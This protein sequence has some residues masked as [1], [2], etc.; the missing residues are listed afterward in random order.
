MVTID[1]VRLFDIQEVGEVLKTTWLD[2]YSAYLSAETI[3]KVT[4]F[5]LDPELLKTQIMDPEVLFLAAKDETSAIV[6]LATA[7]RIEP[8][9][10]QLARLYVLP[11]KQ[12]QGIGTL[13]LERVIKKM[14]YIKTIR[15]EVE[16]NNL[17]GISFCLKQGFSK[18]GVKQD[19][20]EDTV[21]LAVVMEKA[22]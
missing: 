19:I 13:L 5:W 1:E 18:V 12:R 16:E 11:E 3:K 10:L 14:S 15:V 8:T 9:T 6:G 2:T 17:R 20:V 21:L 4:D 7:L 22:I